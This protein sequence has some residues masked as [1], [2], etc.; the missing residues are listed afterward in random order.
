M[1]DNIQL[2]GIEFDATNLVSGLNKVAQRL[3]KLEEQFDSTGKAGKKLNTRIAGLEKKL[4]ETSIANRALEKSQRGLNFQLDRYKKKVENATTAIA[5]LK[6]K[7]KELNVSLRE[8][9]RAN[10]LLAKNLA[11][12][13]VR[14]TKLQKKAI[15]AA[16]ALATLRDKNKQL[17]AAL[18]LSE[19]ETKKLQS[20]VTKLAARVD[21]LEKQFKN[22][23]TR[24]NQYR[25]AAKR[26]GTETSGLG[27]KVIA[28]TAGFLALRAVTVRP[29]RLV[30]C[31]PRLP[32]ASGS[33]DC[34]DGRS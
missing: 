4:R 26:A 9:Q 25:V 6:N 29:A 19:R 34:G 22:A 14:V 20:T 23:Q 33:V 27:A 8:T 31:Q 13:E 21:R 16:A 10:D 1:P 24:I 28:L 12:V 17:S 30:W 7:N 5:A 18:R 15:T 3:D 32:A 11:R 2:L